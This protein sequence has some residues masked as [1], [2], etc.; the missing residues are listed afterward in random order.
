MVRHGSIFD[1]KKIRAKYVTPTCF[2]HLSVWLRNLLR[3]QWCQRPRMLPEWGVFSVV[4]PPNMLRAGAACNSWSL[5][6]SDCSAPAAWASLL[7][8]LFNPPK[9]QYIEKTS[10]CATFLP[11]RSTFLSSDAFSSL[12]FFLLPYTYSYLTSH[13]CISICSF[14]GSLTFKFP[15]IISGCVYICIYI[16]RYIDMYIN[17]YTYIYIYI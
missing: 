15:S 10:C 4:W 12:I 16:Y 14:V 17:I 5:T 3:A 8:F 2:Y 1:R 7:F 13:L 9:S 11:F 6:W